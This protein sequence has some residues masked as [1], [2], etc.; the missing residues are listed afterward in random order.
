MTGRANTSSRFNVTSMTRDKMY[1]IT[2]GT[3]GSRVIYFTANPN[4]EAE[5]IKITMSNPHFG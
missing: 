2:Q 5:I 3:P 1:D 4:G